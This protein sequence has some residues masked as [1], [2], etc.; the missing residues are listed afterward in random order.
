M[1]TET[2]VLEMLGHGA[3]MLEVLNELC[4]FV[5]AQTG[6]IS[7]VF[8][9]DNEGMRLRPVAGPKAPKA[10]KKEI[11]SV[12]SG[13]YAKFSSGAGEGRTL[14]L[15]DINRDPLFQ[16]HSEAALREGL[17]ACFRPIFS[18]EK[19]VRG[20]L[21]VAY[22]QRQPR[23]EPDSEMM[24]RAIHLAAIAIECYRNEQELREFSRRLNQSQDDERRRI[25][26]ELHDST[27]QKLSVLA[28]NLALAQNQISS[29]ERTFHKMMAEC[30][31]ITTDVSE[32]IRTLSYM[33]HPP[34]LDECGLETSIQM[35]SR[36]INRRAG[37]EV[38]LDIPRRLERLSEDAELA[39][40]R[41]VQASLTNI[42]LHSGSAKAVVK[43]EQVS[44]GLAVT[45][46][47]QGR[48]I[49]IGVLERSPLSRGAGVGIAGMKERLKYLGGRLEIESS[50]NGT[51]VRATIPRC[52]F[53]SAKSAAQ[54]AVKA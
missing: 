19:E 7:T 38:E 1:T 13:P 14:T 31:S 3:P 10:W 36:G 52:H 20:A 15:G 26:R 8:L 51:Q 11:G 29:S 33:M 45:I 16:V 2:H 6:A 9:L 4:N 42:H 37:L 41:I 34:L 35:Y 50:E 44:E 30:S 43:I 49:P 54:P 27:G 25:A 46:S 48:G 21:A 28:M 22:P 39:I 5:D 32:E 12:E 17:Q 24:E 47:D 53:R 23:P 18:V 40:F